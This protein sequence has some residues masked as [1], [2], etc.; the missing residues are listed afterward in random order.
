MGEVG[1][2]NSKATM[3]SLTAVGT[4]VEWMKWMKEA[5]RSGMGQLE[6]W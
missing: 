2:Q 5:P 1:L 4:V 3:L 6:G